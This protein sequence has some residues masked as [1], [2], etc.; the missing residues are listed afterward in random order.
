[1]SAARQDAGDL[2]LL[3]GE[4]HDLWES[5]GERL[6]V[7]A[8]SQCQGSKHGAGTQSRS[9]PVAFSGPWTLVQRVTV[10]R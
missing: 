2:L 6:L 9:R 3:D 8:V 4:L 1:V 7:G 10:M 5:G